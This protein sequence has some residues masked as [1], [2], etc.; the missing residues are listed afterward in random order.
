LATGA[1][2]IL[3]VAPSFAQQ[4]SSTAH[5]AMERAKAMEKAVIA[6]WN[7]KDPAKIAALDTSDAVL[8]APDGKVYKG[9]AACRH[10][11]LLRQFFQ[12]IRRFQIHLHRSSAKADLACARPQDRG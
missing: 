10:R 9:R 8:V 5:R 3:I 7:S 1:A 4:K 6:A 11:G 2:L 12:S